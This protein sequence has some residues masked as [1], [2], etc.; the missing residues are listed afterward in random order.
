M[1]TFS[2]IFIEFVG[3][4]PIKFSKYL[5]YMIDYLPR[6]QRIL[7]NYFGSLLIPLYFLNTLDEE[8]HSNILK[9]TK[10]ETQE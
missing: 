10:I 9:Q 1:T 7:L 5:S 8:I 3:W 4:G 2:D 6:F